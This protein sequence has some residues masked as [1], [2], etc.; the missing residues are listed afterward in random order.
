MHGSI[1]TKR[2]NQRHSGLQV[3]RYCMPTYNMEAFDRNNGRKNFIYIWKEMD[4]WLTNK[5]DVENDP[6]D[7][8]NYL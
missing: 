3:P 2:P 8:N 4:C 6:E 7:K 1:D 5:K